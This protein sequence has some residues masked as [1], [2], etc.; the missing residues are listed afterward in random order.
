MF[1]PKYSNTNKLIKNIKEVAVLINELNHKT[2][3]QTV[4]FDYENQAKSMS[5]YSSTSIEGNPLALTDVK[6]LLKQRPECIRD[7]EREVLNYNRALE[8]LQTQTNSP[9]TNKLILKLHQIVMDQLL[10]KALLARFRLEPVVVN[11]PKAKK[12]IFCP[13]DHKEINC[14]MRDLINFIDNNKN[15]I[16]YLIL[17]GIFHKQF[18]IIHPFIDGNGRSAR[19][20]T[21]HLLAAM[22]LNT[23]NLFSFEKYYNN[24]VSKYFEKVGAKGDYYEVKDCLDFTEWIE[25]FTDGIIDELLRV[26][27]ELEAL[28]ISPDTKLEKHDKKIIEYIK[29]H[30]FIEDKTYSGLTTRAKST[31]ILDFKKLIEL[32]YITRHGQGKSTHYKL[33]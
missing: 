13:P 1:K 2:Y 30:G 3:P 24:N 28:S 12:T 17:A 15:E 21:K 26:K 4:L 6:R 14:L 29:K 20:I 31:R 5:S 7:T 11:D 9:L 10:P 33:K 19:L 16:D 8:Y 22:G 23:F 27:K 25:Y 32:G 18:V